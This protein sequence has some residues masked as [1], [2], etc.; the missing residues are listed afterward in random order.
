MDRRGSL[1]VVTEMERVESVLCIPAEEAVIHVQ[2]HVAGS[3]LDEA[4]AVAS[5]LL[6]VAVVEGVL[7]IGLGHVVG[8][9]GN[10]AIP[11]DHRMG[12]VH[13]SN[14]L[15]GGVAAPAVSIPTGLSV[16]D[17]IDIGCAKDIAAGFVEMASKNAASCQTNDGD[18]LQGQIGRTLLGQVVKNNSAI[19]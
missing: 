2:G 19:V 3:D 7:R 8:L 14:G 17:H 18:I 5:R 1:D 4:V 12:Q 15:A 9:D 6:P 11:V 13:G 10:T 16:A